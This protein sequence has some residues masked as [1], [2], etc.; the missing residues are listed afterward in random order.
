MITDL[1]KSFDE[2]TIALNKSEMDKMDYKAQ[3]DSEKSILFHLNLK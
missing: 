1:N 2:K 3:L